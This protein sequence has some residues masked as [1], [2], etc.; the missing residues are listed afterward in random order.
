[1][2]SNIR[3]TVVKLGCIASTALIES[4][5]DERASRNDI[6]VRSFSSG[7]KMDAQSA[8]DLVEIAIS[9]KSDLF[10]V[11]SPNATLE[12]PRSLVKNLSKKA[13]T[14]VISDA[15][16]KRVLEDF[17]KSSIGYII[18]EAD[19]LIGVRKEFL[20]PIEMAL[21]NS[22]VIRVL[23]A[24]GAF[25]ALYEE[26]D[27]LIESTKNNDKYIPKSIIN[28]ELAVNRG[29]FS[30]P[31]ARAKAMASFEMARL[32]GELSAEGAYK[33][34]ERKRYLNIVASAHEL[35][36]A[37]ALL[38]DQAREMEKFSDRVSRH[39]HMYD[40]SVRIKKGLFDAIQ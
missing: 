5:L 24:T 10:L 39:I 17:E 2:R 32:A 3:I 31:Y 35:M 34:K 16:A 40:G 1:M 37:A 23:S 13:P 27:R 14:T 28:K 38:A 8:K 22:D 19:S 29:N 20:D 26:I 9:V 12:E 30:N 15:P 11:V 7:T 6:V 25:R 21:F 33:V 36:H 18:V 4:L